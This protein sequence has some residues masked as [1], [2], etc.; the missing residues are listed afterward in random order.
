MPDLIVR[1]GGSDGQ[2]TLTPVG[3]LDMASAPELQSAI[4]SVWRDGITDLSLD[5]R[6]LDFID[7]T[8]VRLMIEVVKRCQF[9]GCQLEVIRGIDGVQR[10]FDLCGLEDAV[11]FRNGHGIGADL[12]AET[13][14]AHGRS[15]VLG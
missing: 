13:G 12:V 11:P 2:R 5:L 10:V 6:E 9:A 8:G 3:E 15:D 7:S 4:E 14:A 1:V